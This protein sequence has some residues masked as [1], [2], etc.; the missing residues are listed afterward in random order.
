[1]ELLIAA[2]LF[3][4][5]SHLVP[6]APGVRGG[7]VERLGRRGFLTAYSLVSLLALGAVIWAFRATEP[8]PWLYVASPASRLAAVLGMAVV[9]LLLVARLTTPAAG[10]E[11]R[12]I[13]RLTAAPGSLGVLLWALLHLLNV[14]EAR[15]VVVFAGMALIAAA[16]LV[17]NLLLAEA[18]YRRVGRLAPGVLAE[19]GFWR[20]IGWRRLG[21]ALAVYLALLLLHSVVIGPNPLAG[22]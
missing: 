3:L 21:L 14:G 5:A 20:E 16:A 22:L 7:L 8:G 10:P 1:M 11:P 4:I 13:Y 12:G 2:T 18:G 6:S 15:L 9:V 17:K 19:P